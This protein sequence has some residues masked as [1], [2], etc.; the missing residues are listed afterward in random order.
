M[1]ATPFTL[2]T[3]LVRAPH[4][5]VRPQDQSHLLY[6]PRTDELHLLRPEAYLVYVLFDGLNDIDDI[7]STIS[8]LSG[9]SREAAA[10]AVAILVD[11]LLTRGLITEVRP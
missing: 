9:T 2:S 1:D 4:C 11:N 7:V 8:A 5:V 10:D 6:N 3:V